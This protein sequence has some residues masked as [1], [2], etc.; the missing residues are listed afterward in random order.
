MKTTN[1]V[2]GIECLQCRKLY[3]GE[4]RNSLEA[5]LKQHLY[6]I[7]KES[8][9][10]TLYTHFRSHPVVQLRIAGLESNQGWLLTH[11]QIKEQFCI[12]KLCTCDPTGMNEKYYIYILV[13]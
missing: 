5:R 13:I 4:T 12:Q 7:S 3:I 1:I 6:H 10:T 2:Y 11:R 9:K 8:V